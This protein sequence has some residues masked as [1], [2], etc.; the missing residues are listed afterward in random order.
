MNRPR[1]YLITPPQFDPSAFAELLDETLAA[2]DV[3]CLQVRLKGVDDAKIRQAVR[4]VQPIARAH[5]V[6]LLLNDRPDLAVELG[7]D[8]A[9]IGQQDMPYGEARKHLGDDAI[10]GVT[11]HDSIHLAMLAGEAGADYVAFGAFYPT[12]TKQAKT[13]VTPDILQ[14]WQAMATLPCVAIGGITPDNVAPLFMADFIAVSSAVWDHPKNPA[15][16]IR[17]FSAALGE[18]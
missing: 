7:C 3:A 18:K 13:T 16:A 10:I 2:G 17:S 4:A 8:G 1:L 14:R 11:C 9:H 5:N 15:A 6:P 12:A